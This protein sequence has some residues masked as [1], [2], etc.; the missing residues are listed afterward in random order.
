MPSYCGFGWSI[1]NIQGSPRIA[2]NGGINGFATAS[3]MLPEENVFVAIFSNC[4][5]TDPTDAVNRAAAIAIGEPFDW[6]K[7]SLDAPLMQSYQAVYEKTPD[8]QRIITFA[9]GQLF[10]MRSGGARYAIFPFAKDKFFFEG[11]TLSLEFNRDARGEIVSVTS[12][13]TGSDQTW[14]KTDQPIPSLSAIEVDPAILQGHVGK[15]IL[16]ADV[17][18]HVFLDGPLYLQVSGQRKLEMIPLETHE[19]VLKD[20]DIKI[21]FTTNDNGQTTGLIL[22]QNGDHPAE[23]VE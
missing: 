18:I 15:Y 14:L 6:E 7:I 9:D 2:H 4:T 3:L 10:S 11:D 17:Y 12:K 21:S 19:F 13:S 22:H 16:A 23:K 1:G 8:N 5:C 20:T